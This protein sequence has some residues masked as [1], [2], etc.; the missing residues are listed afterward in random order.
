MPEPMSGTMA[1]VLSL[2]PGPALSATS[3]APPNA[4]P[5][6]PAAAESEPIASPP[7]EPTSTPEAPAEA[8]SGA[9]EHAEEAEAD[10]GEQPVAKP[11]QPFSERLSEVV[12]QRRAAEE[13]ANRAVEA[14]ATLA[15]QVKSLMATIEKQAAPKPET[16]APPAEAARPDRNRFDD[17]D[18]YDQ[19]LIDWAADRA[20]SRAAA[21]TSRIAEQKVA[22][23]RA[24]DEK[25]KADADVAAQNEITARDWSEKRTKAVE[26]HPDYAE[27]AERD[28]LQIT[29]PMAHAIVNSDNGPEI[30]YWLGQ[31]PEEAAR[32]AQIGNPVRTV[33]EIGKIAAAIAAPPK[34]EVSKAPRPIP[35]TVGNNANAGPRDVAEM[36]TEE[37]AAHRMPRLQAERRASTLG[38]PT[39]PRT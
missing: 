31:H 3:D 5:E 30:A 28:D 23:Q 6:A 38:I 2:P 37:Y 10:A 36:T 22:E 26:S 39:A 4:P 25:A 35:R 1:D 7:A 24:A 34:P 21:E 29:V 16:P 12:A 32:I 33:Y 19:A 8:E 9:V 14:A 17:P 18:A 13:R 15:D 27:V 11:K 20:A